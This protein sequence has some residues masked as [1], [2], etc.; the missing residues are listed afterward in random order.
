R[1]QNHQLF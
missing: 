1:P